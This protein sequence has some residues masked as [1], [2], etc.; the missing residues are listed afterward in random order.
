MSGEE[1]SQGKFPL[2]RIGYY[3][4][5][6]VTKVR[7]RIKRLTVVSLKPDKPSGGNVLL[8]YLVEPF[9]DLKPGQPV[10][11]LH[12]NYWE[13]MQ[14]ARTFLEL[15]YCVD[16]ISFFNDVFI[17]KKDY[18]FFIDT[19]HNLER[20]TPFLNKDCV[21]ILHIDT[22]HIL[23]HDT[24]ECNRLLA[25]QQ[26]RGVTLKPRRF[27]MPNLAI[28]HADCGTILGNEFTMSTFRY[29]NKPL[30]PIP[31]ST[32]V[33]YPWPE[34]KDFEACRKRFLWFSSGGMVHKG[35][36]LLLEAFA[37][38]PDYHLTICGPV[39]REEDFK[40]FYYK[41][42]Y[43]T[44]NIRVF[45]WVDI[46]SPEFAEITN[47]CLGLVY[48]SCSEGQSGAVV[49]CLHASL[50]PILSYQS[51][52]DVGEDF[53]SVLKTCSIEEIKESVKRISN[54]P[55]ATLKEMARKAWEFARAN[56]TKEKFAAA[57]RDAV[58][59]IIS[60]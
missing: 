5:F 50:I 54:L 23:F 47:N 35:L 14:I 28:E 60:R 38:M 43:Q 1:R 56:H 15:G 41:E 13:C 44:L 8:S 6:A 3:A 55:L 32:P 52:V 48:P 59:Q 11:I 46:S 51:G 34:K 45:G 18:A 20:L 9:R 24:A 21:K 39:D 42:L 53:G 17:P 36:D 4:S 30:Y 49:T 16:V 57:Y 37:Q 7:N 33:L 2:G 40:A 58:K 12:T 19:R 29:A 10:P 31:I 22:A 27:E 25:L 26:R